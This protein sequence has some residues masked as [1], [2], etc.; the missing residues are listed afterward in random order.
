M[1]IPSS[2]L[3][4]NLD[5]RKKITKAD[6]LVI[7]TYYREFCLLLPVY[8]SVWQESTG[9]LHFWATGVALLGVDWVVKERFQFR[10]G[11]SMPFPKRV[12]NGYDSWGKNQVFDVAV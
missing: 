9:N 4:K 1:L 2:N 3:A 5:K 6:A 10:Q 8:A 7:S 12:L 11:F